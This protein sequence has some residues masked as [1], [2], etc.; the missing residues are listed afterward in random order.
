MCFSDQNRNVY[1]SWHLRRRRWEIYWEQLRAQV[2][3]FP[4]KRRRRASVLAVTAWR[5]CC[6]TGGSACIPINKDTHRATGLQCAHPPKTSIQR[7]LKL[8]STR[9]CVWHNFID[10]AC[11]CA[12]FLFRSLVSL[13][14]APMASEIKHSFIYI[15]IYVSA[16]RRRRWRRRRVSERERKQ[17]EGELNV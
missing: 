13:G 5:A 8:L 6:L 9:R 14:S 7:A 4:P 3:A 10:R 16:A 2:A 11:G 15:Y 12:F 17:R 1:L